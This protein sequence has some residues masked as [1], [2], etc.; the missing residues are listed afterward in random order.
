MRVSRFRAVGGQKDDCIARVHIVAGADNDP[1][2]RLAFSITGKNIKPIRP[3]KK[4][5][6]G[7]KHTR[8]A[9]QVISF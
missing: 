7:S 5:Q 4:N 2:A 8:W 3:N 6:T 9:E 1:V